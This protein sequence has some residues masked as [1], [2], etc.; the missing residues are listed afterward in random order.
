MVKR[1]NVRWV[2]SVRPITIAAFA[3]VAEK[4]KNAEKEGIMLANKKIQDK[5]KRNKKE[6]LIIYFN[7]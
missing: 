4:G 2:F 6:V 5:G 1:H 3:R 7:S